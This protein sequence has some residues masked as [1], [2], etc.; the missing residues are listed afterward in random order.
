MMWTEMVGWVGM[1][2]SIATS[3]PQFVKSVKERSTRGLSLLTYQILFAAMACYLIRAIAIK[4]PVFI[5]SGVANLIL[6]A[7]MMYLFKIFPEVPSKAPTQMPFLT[8][9]R[10]ARL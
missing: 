4:D 7:G 2:F 5:A 3:V 6:T 9:S 10:L 1:V 8:S